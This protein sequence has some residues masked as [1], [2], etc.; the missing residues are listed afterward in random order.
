MSCGCLSSAPADC[1]RPRPLLWPLTVVPARRLELEKWMSR[2]LGRVQELELDYGSRQRILDTGC[3][4]GYFLHICRYLGHEVA[5]MEIDALPMFRAM[6]E[7]LGLKRILLEV[8]PFQPLPD[9]GQRSDLSPASWSALTVTRA[10]RSGARRNGGSSSTTGKRI[11]AREAECSSG[12]IAKTTD[13]IPTK[14]CAGSS[15]SAARP[16]DG[17]RVTLPAASQKGIAAGG[18]LGRCGAANARSR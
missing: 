12:S 10:K 16:V 1:V 14:T 5:G 6:T 4:T 13:N 15:S 7:M 3:G 8:K 9:L 18:I 17:Q 11:C 2:N